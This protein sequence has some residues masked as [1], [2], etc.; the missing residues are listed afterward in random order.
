G[1]SY[2]TPWQAGTTLPT[3]TTN[4]NNQFVSAYLDQASLEDA[5]KLAQ[6]TANKEIKAAK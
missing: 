4:F 3:V 2:A 1:A 6:E 5:M